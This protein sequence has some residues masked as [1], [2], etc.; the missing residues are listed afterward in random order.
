MDCIFIPLSSLDA[1]LPLLSTPLILPEH[2]RSAVE[3]RQRDYF[4][5]RAGAQFLYDRHQVPWDGLPMYPETHPLRG[6]PQWPE[7]FIGSISHSKSLAVACMYPRHK[8]RSVGIDTELIMS[9]ER[10]QQVRSQ[11]LHPRESWVTTP[12]ELSLV[13]SFKE[14]IYKALHPLLQR[15][16]GFQE[17]WIENPGLRQLPRFTGLAPAPPR[18]CVLKW[19]PETLLE[20]DL[21]A[22]FTT[23]KRPRLAGFAQWWTHPEETG[24]VL[25]HYSF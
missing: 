14:S 9:A 23:S 7:G 22:Y 25:T 15:F 3:K 17:L 21:I 4:A 2:L 19:Q 10:A 24:F 6:A 13:F 18:H 20:N 5:G 16:I 11:I 1:T 12:L 8:V